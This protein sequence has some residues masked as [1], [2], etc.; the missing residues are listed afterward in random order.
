MGLYTGEWLAWIRP[1]VR[2][3]GT[4][5]TCVTLCAYSLITETA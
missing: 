2:Q 1:R 5:I 4:A 3:V